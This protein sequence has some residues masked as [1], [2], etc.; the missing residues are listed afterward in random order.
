MLLNQ[1]Q[2]QLFG[3]TTDNALFSRIACGLSKAEIEKFRL[4]AKEDEEMERS[5]SIRPSLS[6]QAKQ[7]IPNKSESDLSNSNTSSLISTTRSTCVDTIPTTD[8]TTSRLG[9]RN[10]TLDNDNANQT[11]TDST[12]TGYTSG[13]FPVTRFN[14]AG[15]QFY[16]YLSDA[17][18]VVA[19]E[20]GMPLED[21]LIAGGFLTRSAA[22]RQY[23]TFC[24][25]PIH[26]VTYEQ[27][28][29]E[30]VFLYL[31]SLQVLATALH[32]VRNKVKAG[33][34]TLNPRIKKA[35]T[36]LN[37]RYKACC[38]L[39]QEARAKCDMSKI[40]QNKSF[41]SADRLLYYYAVHECRVAALDEMFEG[42]VQQCVSRYRRALII[43]E[44]ISICAT[45]DID[46]D[47]LLKY[48]SSIDH[49]LKHLENLW[50]S[51]VLSSCSGRNG[52]AKMERNKS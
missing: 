28:Q 36:E 12:T 48:K 34:L 25:D 20:H 5:L 32:T 7:F 39:C 16:C 50:S 2:E 1:K 40:K 52:G 29:A 9:N 10:N 37:R 14:E 31:R 49:R 43:L 13:A 18:N 47:R 24:N 45:H 22:H 33:E 23:E 27:R 26:N 42:S 30:Q 11:S 17:I 21:Q 19:Q 41:K 46:K 3:G 38:R 4:A 51:K 44:G 8:N 6:Q 15:L 35:V